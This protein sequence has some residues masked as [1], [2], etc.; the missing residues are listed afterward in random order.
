MGEQL[1]TSHTAIESWVSALS[2]CLSLCLPVSLAANLRQSR[3]Q[4]SGP[5]FAVCLSATSL[6]VLANLTD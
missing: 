1:Q 3:R 5:F 2:V 4:A 6:S